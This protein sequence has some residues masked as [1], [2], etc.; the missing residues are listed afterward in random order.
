MPP[1]S[2]RTLANSAWYHWRRSNWLVDPRRWLA[3][4]ADV[5]IDRPIFMLGNQGGGLTLIGR[6]LRRHH[7]VVSISGDHTYWAGADEMQRVMELR[8]PKTLKL[9]RLPYQVEAQHDRLTAPR[10]WS[11]ATDALLP[12]YRNTADDLTEEDAETFRHLIREALHRHGKGRAGLRFFD[13]SQVYTVK[14]SY[15]HAILQD[16]NPYYILITRD[17]Y[18]A[19]YRAAQ[20][21]AIDMAR[22]AATMSLEERVALCAEHWSNAMRCV[23]EDGAAVPRFKVMHFEQFLTD[24]AASL[25]ELCA[26]LDLTYSDDLLPQPH[27]TVP[28]GSRFRDRWYPLRLGVNRSYLTEMPPH[29]I[30][31]IADR[32]APIAEQLGYETPST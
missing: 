4:Y 14:L 12:A 5:P 13:K 2:V 23:L 20:G 8:L 17:P 15:L 29:L 27:H 6:M 26:F 10:S 21:K 28:F 7:E 30:E 31:L 16:A 25:Q 18:V 19:C 11:Y 22:Y 32:C 24:P 1:L 9:A 3:D